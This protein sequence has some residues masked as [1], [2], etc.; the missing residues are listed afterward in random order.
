LSVLSEFL[1]R[2]R[3]RC[4]WPVTVLS[5]EVMEESSRDKVFNRALKLLAA[6]PRSIAELRE[7]LLEKK[8]ATPEIV[9]EAVERLKELGYLNDDLFA[10]SYASYRVSLRP[11]GRSRVAQDLARKRVPRKTADEALELVYG[12]TTEEELI[13]RAIEKWL[14][15]KR[16]P[17]SREEAKKLF[18]HLIRLGFPY[19]L[20]IDKV[21][22]VSIELKKRL[23]L[24]RAPSALKTV[25]K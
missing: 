4:S 7:R 3:Q 11:L 18:D 25:Q 5:L 17:A 13:D 12:E 9:E 20:V 19:D 8:W 21:R 24:V 16:R 2:L 23:R 22:T 6:K 14:R 15:I 1:E 10:Y